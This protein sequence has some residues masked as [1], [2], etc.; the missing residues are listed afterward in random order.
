MDA[1]PTPVPL[2]P[3]VSV[4]MSVPAMIGLILLVGAIC[5]GVAL[6]APYIMNKMWR[7][8]GTTIRLSTPTDSVTV[9]ALTSGDIAAGDITADS[10]YAGIL[11]VP[12]GTT[13]NR[14]S[15]PSEGTLYYNTSLKT[16]ETWNGNIWDSSNL[17]MIAAQYG[18]AKGSAI[19][20]G[21]ASYPHFDNDVS[22]QTAGVGATTLYTNDATLGTYINLSNFCLTP[23]QYVGNFTCDS[24]VTVSTSGNLTIDVS[25]QSSADDT[26]ASPA[27]VTTRTYSLAGADTGPHPVHFEFSVPLTASLN[28]YY[29]MSIE[30]TNSAGGTWNFSPVVS[31]HFSVKLIPN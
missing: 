19:A 2:F 13:A 29:R 12:K 8:D 26:F 21:T 18:K 10:L 24:F 15:S 6:Y 28:D 5:I 22:T 17:D 16:L 11:I 30:V 23:T 27:N 25:L 14:P 1:S 3:D 7:R 20:S 31:S 4:T 9:G